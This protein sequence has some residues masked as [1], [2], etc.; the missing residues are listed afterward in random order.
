MR[1]ATTLYWY[2]KGLNDDHV[3]AI[4]C[5]I[6]SGALPNLVDL[7]LSS[8][9]IGDTGMIAFADAIK[10]TDEFPMGAL[11]SLTKLWLN[12]NQIGDEGMHAFSAAISSGSMGKLTV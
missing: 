8:N 6:S 12:H 9:K 1:Q 7:R 11:A 10:P 3:K 2:S 5:L 4:A